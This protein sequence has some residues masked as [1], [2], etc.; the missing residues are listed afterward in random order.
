MRRPFFFQY[1][2]CWQARENAALRV[3]LQQSHRDDFARRVPALLLLGQWLLDFQS[4]EL[5]SNKKR[6]DA[7][8]L[9]KAL[10]IVGFLVAVNL[11]PGLS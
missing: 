4:F 1:F 10:H 6:R 2:Q 8:D 5:E 11:L 7:R 9:G 3:P